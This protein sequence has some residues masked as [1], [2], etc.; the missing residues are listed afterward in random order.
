MKNAWTALVDTWLKDPVWL[1]LVLLIVDARV[2]PQPS[3]VHMAAWLDRV[4]VPFVVIANKT[5]RMLHAAALRQ[6]ALWDR[7]LAADSR[8]A[9][10]PAS[11]R[12]RKGRVEVL[13]W[14]Q[15]EVRPA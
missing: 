5:D 4:R 13:K 10:V 11:A 9:I 14:V 7:A 15:R 2:D 3:D 6:L 12:T 8:K 1:K